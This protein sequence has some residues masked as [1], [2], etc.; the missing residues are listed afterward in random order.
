VDIAAYEDGDWV[1]RFF[2]QPRP[3]AT[4]IQSGSCLGSEIPLGTVGEI[5]PARG[6]NFEITLPDFTRDPVF[7]KFGEHGKF[8]VIDLALREKKIG[9]VLA[10]IKPEDGPDRGLNVQDE[11][12]EP[13]TFTTGH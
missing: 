12:R 7:D 8:G 11:Y 9:R 6:G 4:I 5:D 2:F 1:C 13:L 3:E 10:T